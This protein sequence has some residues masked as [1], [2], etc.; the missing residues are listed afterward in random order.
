VRIVQKFKTP[1]HP[2][3][4]VS[5]FISTIGIEIKVFFKK[6][7]LITGRKI[8]L[9]TKMGGQVALFTNEA[10]LFDGTDYSSWRE[11]MKIYLKS[12]GFDVWDSVVCK[13]WYLT[14]SKKKSKNAKEAKRNNSMTLKE[15]HN[16]LSHQVKEN[17][18]HCTS[19]KLLWIQ[20]EN[21]HQI[22]EQNTEEENSYQIKIQNIEEENYY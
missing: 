5:V 8:L 21:S 7:S 18:G 14:T 10:P 11:R 12:R 19:V 3:L 13:P 2:P 20:L 22:K 4:S 16:G 17:M 9:N 6:N 15:I 1:I